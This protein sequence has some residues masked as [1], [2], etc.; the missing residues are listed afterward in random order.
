MSK[1]GSCAKNS[2]QE[3]TPS[4]NGSYKI[5]IVHFIQE[6]TEGRGVTL[7][8]EEPS[9]WEK[10]MAYG[11]SEASQTLCGTPHPTYRTITGIKKDGGFL[12]LL[13]VIHFKIISPHVFPSVTS[14]TV[15]KKDN[16]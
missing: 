16:F 2:H 7:R 9:G 14:I 13:P 8:Y 1:L 10:N 6:S 12:G 4:G 15:S 3:P 5:I 11:S